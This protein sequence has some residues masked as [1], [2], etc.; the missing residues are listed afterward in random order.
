MYLRTH[1]KKMKNNEWMS[2]YYC[3]TARITTCEIEQ[4]PTEAEYQWCVKVVGSW[5]N[6]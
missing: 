6:T 4:Q 1:K 2:V 3:E 5:Q